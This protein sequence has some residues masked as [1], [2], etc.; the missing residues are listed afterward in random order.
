M[1]IAEHDPEKLYP[2]NKGV[3]KMSKA[4]LHKYASTKEKNLPKRKA[5]RKSARSR[6]R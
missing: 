3:A 5:S 1:A 2:E 6:G 4:E